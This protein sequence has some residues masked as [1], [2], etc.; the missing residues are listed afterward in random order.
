MG[1]LNVKLRN[2]VLE[3]LMLQTVFA[4]VSIYRVLTANTVYEVCGAGATL[5]GSSMMALITS[6]LVID[7][8]LQ[9]WCCSKKPKLKG[10]CFGGL[11]CFDSFTDHT[12]M[13]VYHAI[14]HFAVVMALISVTAECI[15]LSDAAESSK[16]A[17]KL[18]VGVGSVD[19]IIERDNAIIMIICQLFVG[20]PWRIYTIKVS[21]GVLNAIYLTETLNFPSL[22]PREALRALL[23][24]LGT[25]HGIDLAC[26]ADIPVL[27]VLHYQAF[28][29]IY[30][31]IGLSAEQGPALIETQW[32]NRGKALNRWWLDRVGVVRDASGL[33]TAALLLQLPGDTAAYDSLL[34]EDEAI[35]AS[36][37]ALNFLN[38]VSVTPNAPIRRDFE[39]PESDPVVHFSSYSYIWPHRQAGFIEQ[40]VG[41]ELVFLGLYRGS[42]Y[43]YKQAILND[44]ICMP[45]ES[46]VEFVCTMKG[47]EGSGA[48]SK[49]LT[50]ASRSAER[51]GCGTIRV[52]VMGDSPEDK[53]RFEREGFVVCKSWTD[54]IAILIMRY[55][56]G[57]KEDCYFEME[58]PLGVDT[59]IAIHSDAWGF[60]NDRIA[61]S[62]SGSS[63]SID[64]LGHSIH[65]IAHNLLENT[66]G[67]IHSAR[68]YM[69]G[70]NEQT[71]SGS[72]VPQYGHHYSS[73]LSPI[74][75]AC[76]SDSAHGNVDASVT[77]KGCGD[78]SASKE[79][80][81]VVKD[82]GQFNLA[83]QEILSSTSSDSGS[84]RDDISVY[85]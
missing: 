31:H 15:T 29:S 28:E 26:E 10:I 45:G 8:G 54:P 44:K 51:L 46:Y 4:V 75:R 56:F 59:G 22:Y 68:D 61:L 16:T 7:K 25:P 14:G 47:R 66:R 76:I 62:D 49:L 67:L 83:N 52:S 34:C 77:S 13:Q 39:V 65:D 71:P 32:R 41:P 40:L 11:C 73:V 82:G 1:S 78:S 72:N 24:D 43:R 84:L 63:H 69:Y 50:W 21:K 17:F 19:R 12:L 36:E 33:V 9:C 60:V 37:S 48:R 5:F 20:V 53:D 85:V 57:I 35:D 38:N 30:K 55:V 18:P 70:S 27:A 6:I 2:I 3:D 79:V 64:D 80:N 42:I 74:F 58:N 23:R 81:L